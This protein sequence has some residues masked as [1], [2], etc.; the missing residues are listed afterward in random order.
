MSANFSSFQ[1]C[2]ACRVLFPNAHVHHEFLHQLRLQTVKKSFREL[3]KRHHPDAHAE[4]IDTP[5][6]AGMFRKANQ[7]YQ[8]LCSYIRERDVNPVN[9][10]PI[11]KP[12][13][14][15]DTRPKPQPQTTEKVFRRRPRHVKLARNPDDVYYDGPLP[16]FRLKLGLFLYYKGYVPYSA[17]VKALI[18]QRDMRPPIGDLA[19]AWGWLEPP[20]VSIIRSATE[21]TGSFGEKAVELG[22]L[23]R[24]QVGVLLLHQRLMQAHIGRYFVSKGYLTERELSKYIEEHVR[25]NE[26]RRADPNASGSES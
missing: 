12:E 9:K 10:P 8:L 2:E 25:F 19:V 24:S 6:D 4:H 1:L 14:Q 15:Q 5:L 3:A 21:L 20:F 22:L 23:T 17:V 11:R 13:A 18:W 16:T 26:E 7:A